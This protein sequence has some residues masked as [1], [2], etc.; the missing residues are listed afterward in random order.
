MKRYLLI[1]GVLLFALWTKPAAADTVEPIGVIAYDLDST[2]TGTPIG[3]FDII[4]LTGPDSGAPFNVV[5][6]LTITDA[7]LTLTGPSAP[8]SPI[9]VPD[10][11]PG[12]LSDAFGFPLASLAFDPSSVFTSALLQGDL[13]TTTLMLAD[14]TTVTVG[15][16]ISALITPSSGSSLVA[17]T[18]FAE[19]DAV[20]S[21]EPG[22]FALILVGLLAIVGLKT[23]MFR[24]LLGG[25]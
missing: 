15:G 23:A 5:T 25:R 3:A 18:D 2:I 7:T 10:I 9:S 12:Y 21:P 6:S 13:S 1:A 24:T 22:T 20:V 19:I 11:G 17:D 8:S 16:T 4:N 14:G